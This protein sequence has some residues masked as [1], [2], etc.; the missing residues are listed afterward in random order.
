MRTFRYSILDDKG[1]ISRGMVSLPFEDVAPAVRY[2]ER[3]GGVVLSVK[4]VDPAS[5]AFHRLLSSL[6]PVKR[7]ELAEIL[8]NLSMLLSAGVPVLTAINDIMEDLRNP[9]L[10]QTLRF[11]CTDIESG[12][13]FAEAVN[14]HPQVFSSL[15]RQMCRIGEETGR[16]DEMLKRS[17]EHLLHI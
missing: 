15:I 8:N 13:T 4:P 9:V 17:S 5:A 12:Q 3:R 7:K 10:V 11:I 6:R 14:R 2:L 16:L 1:K